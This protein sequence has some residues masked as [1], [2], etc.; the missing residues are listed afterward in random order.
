M[1]TRKTRDRIPV[2]ARY[3]RAYCIGVLRDCSFFISLGL[4]VSLGRIV[5][6]SLIAVEVVEGLELVWRQRGEW[7]A[8]D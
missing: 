8:I 4:L 3:R 5:K 2:P 1:V 7:H 6:G